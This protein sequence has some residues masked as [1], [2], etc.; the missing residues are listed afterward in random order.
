MERDPVL[1]HGISNFIKESMMERSDKFSWCICKRC[2]TLV[3]F[4]MKENINICKNCN[5]D[6]V[7][8]IQTPYAF[9]LFIQELETM[10]IQ[11][12]LNT[13]LIDMPID[14]AELVRI[15]NAGGGADADGDV[16]DASD[17]SD[18]SADASDSDDAVAADNIDY[19]LFNSQIDNFAT[20]NTI[21][22]ER[23]WKDTY[24]NNFDKIKGGMF[25]G[26]E[27]DEEEDDEEKKQEGGKE[28]EDED[29]EEEDDEEE[30]DE[31]DEEDV[32]EKEDRRQTHTVK[33]PW[34][35]MSDEYEEE[36]VADKLADAV[37]R[38]KCLDEEGEEYDDE[39]W[40]EPPI[41][42][43]TVQ[44]MMLALDKLP[45]KAQ[46]VITEEGFYSHTEFAAMM[47]PEP[48]TIKNKIPKLPDGTQVYRIGH[49][50]QNYDLHNY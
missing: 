40:Y 48:Y 3:A 46:L 25:D 28:D 44:Q 30:D 22:D 19:S 5:N 37:Y 17:A 16:D 10:G 33:E 42:T 31:D 6:D 45:R 7:A 20:K 49:S 41:K 21:I 9:K 15:S 4:N 26:D 14:Q 50:K 47:L 12:R 38:R 1:S 29:D 34:K 18:A 13:E 11:P 36:E 32:E 2:G 35:S 43:I 23:T 8:V 27:D 24:D 39:C